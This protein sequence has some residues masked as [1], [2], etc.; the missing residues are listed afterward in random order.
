M[1]PKVDRPKPFL[2][3][4]G[5][6][7][8][9]FNRFRKFLPDNLKNY[10]IIDLFAGSGA[11]IFNILPR[12]AI[13]NDIN[14]QLMNAYSIIRDNLEGLL[15]ELK[16]HD[17]NDSKEYYLQVRKNYN[18]INSKIYPEIYNYID[19]KYINYQVERIESAGYFIY[20]NSRSFNGLYR[21]NKSGEFN[22]G[23][24]QYKNKCI[25][26]IYNEK[27]L[28]D[29]SK[30]LNNNHVFIT[31][32]HYNKINEYLN[33][34]ARKL[35][36]LEIDQ[37]IQKMEDWQFNYYLE[38]AKKFNMKK[39]YILDPPYYNNFTNFIP[40]DWNIDQYIHFKKFILEDIHQAG[41]IFMLCNSDEDDIIE[42]F[43]HASFYFYKHKVT[44]SISCKKDQRKPV[45]EILITNYKINSLYDYL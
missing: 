39:F 19:D 12:Y 45:N 17:E 8:K 40:I 22:V 30:Y 4:V 36:L 27:I 2:R 11:F 31:A 1:I 26:K 16:K 20:L 7:Q 18:E 6:K 38:L 14:K 34:P 28:T 33:E 32:L 42:L 35:G 5:G 15:C 25:K 29:I 24:N 21:E 44:R 41:D 3:W 43:E 13:I 37:E 10:L 23:Y 9:N